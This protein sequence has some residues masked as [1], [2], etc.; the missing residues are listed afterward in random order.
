MRVE[1]TAFDDVRVGGDLG[2]VF[3]PGAQPGRAQKNAVERRAAQEEPGCDRGREPQVVTLQIPVV[4]QDPGGRET[5]R[6]GSQADG[7]RR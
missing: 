5:R 3:L 1:R 7:A 6:G 4:G 2:A